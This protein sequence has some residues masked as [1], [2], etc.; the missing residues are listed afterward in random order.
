MFEQNVVYT[1][2]A[3]E[4]LTVLTHATHGS[5]RRALSTAVSAAALLLLA[6]FSLLERSPA[7]LVGVV[8]STIG[9]AAVLSA[10]Q[11]EEG[12]V[13]THNALV[14]AL[15]AASALVAASSDL[16]RVFVA[17]EVLSAS[18]LSLTAYH[19]EREGAEAAL[20]YVMLCGAG[21][22]LALAGI[23]LVVL[24]TGSTTVEAAARASLLAKALLLAGFGVEAALFPL[25]FWL[26]DAHMAAPSTASAV[27]SGIATESAAVLVYRLV[28]GDEVVRSI[29][30][31]LAL[32]GA[33]VGNLSAYRQDDFKRL[34]AFS[35]VANVNYIMLAWATGNPLA[36]RYAFLHVAA[37]GLLKASLFLVAGVLLA[38]YGTRR[39]SELSGALSGDNAL[40][41]AVILSAV[42]LTG[43]PPA[44]TFWSEVFMGVGIFQHSVVL[45]LGFAAAVVVSFA[46]YFRLIYTL[47]SGEKTGRAKPLLPVVAALTL[48]AL[49]LVASPLYAAM[50]D[51]F[52]V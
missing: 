2:L 31:P 18:V 17:W 25:H 44:L 21:T 40:K 50:L 47:S 5:L 43:A 39:L 11:L 35:S 29:V 27:L 48:V 32:L 46:Y 34:L 23:A 49:N 30:A 41:A 16:V 38:V 28:M 7:G 10:Y 33:L 19:R 51:Y 14:L 52:R 22:A 37:H 13:S 20:K 1:V 6:L 15:C 8:A 12:D 45:G 42:G 4:L 3:G 36:A 24:E 9:L 26:P